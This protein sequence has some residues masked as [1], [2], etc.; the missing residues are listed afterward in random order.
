MKKVISM[1]TKNSSEK[2]T[3]IYEDANDDVHKNVD[4]DIQTEETE[5]DK[6]DMGPTVYVIKHNQK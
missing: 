3:N 2:S 6:D 5:D 1:L 4:F